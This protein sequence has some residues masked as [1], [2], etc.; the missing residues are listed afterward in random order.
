MIGTRADEIFHAN[1]DS[2]AHDS[3]VEPRDS[4]MLPVV[5]S[6]HVWA[7][8]IPK[9]PAPVVV[10]RIVSAYHFIHV[11]VIAVVETLVRAAF[12]I[13]IAEIAR[14]V[15]DLTIWQIAAIGW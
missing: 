1:I 7:L 8:A 5:H 14:E 11:V 9:Q 2:T 10:H 15:V 12:A 4:I 6:R 13:A 3:D